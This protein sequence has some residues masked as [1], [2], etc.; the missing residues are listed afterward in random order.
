M[1]ERLI[2]K[3]VPKF[4]IPQINTPLLIQYNPLLTEE[5]PKPL[6]LKNY[7]DLKLNLMLQMEASE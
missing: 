6:E 2:G 4:R 5:L 1:M 7:Q 3:L